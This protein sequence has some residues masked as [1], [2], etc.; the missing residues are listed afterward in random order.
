MVDF[1]PEGDRDLRMLVPF[2]STAIMASRA[3]EVCTAG[4]VQP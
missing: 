1:S 3:G 2:W 4:M